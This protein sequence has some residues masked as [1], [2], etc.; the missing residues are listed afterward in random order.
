MPIKGKN[1]IK[2]KENVWKLKETQTRSPIRAF[3]KSV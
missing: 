2:R 3:T 1:K